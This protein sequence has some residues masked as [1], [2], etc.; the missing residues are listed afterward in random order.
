MRAERKS[1]LNSVYES[2][3]TAIAQPGDIPAR[4]RNTP[5]A[6]LIM[7]I[8]FNHVIDVNDKPQLFVV[9]CID[10]RLQPAIPPYYSFVLRTPASR[11]T[12]SEFALAYAVSKGVRHAALIGHNDCGMAKVLM[13][14]GPVT[15]A[16][17]DQGWPRDR[18]EQYV[19][20]QGPR[21]AIE[22]EVDFLQSE[23]AHIS[24]L[25]PKVEFAPL[26]ADVGDGCLYI[27]NWYDANHQPGF[28]N[29]QDLARLK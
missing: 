1:T 23:F 26:I 13:H 27:P 29:E 16:L 18:A 3:L 19:A 28:V 21:Y 6:E 7:A 11:L 2:R 8:N 10:F 25:F 14:S 4:W 12:G 22:N 24:R 9:T 15:N 17:V 20:Q 5:L